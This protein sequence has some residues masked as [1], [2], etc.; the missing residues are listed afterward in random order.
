MLNFNKY[1]FKG[2]TEGSDRSGENKFAIV[3]TLFAHFVKYGEYSRKVL[4]FK[5]F[6]V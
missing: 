1:S 6:M 2:L 4:V 3:V 5:G